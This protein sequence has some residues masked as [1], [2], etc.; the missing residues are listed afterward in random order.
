MGGAL[1]MLTGNLTW[2]SAQQAL[3]APFGALP[4]QVPFCFVSG[5]QWDI[6]RQTH[7]W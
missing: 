1:E 2:L 6:L 7:I 4:G 5:A 3:G